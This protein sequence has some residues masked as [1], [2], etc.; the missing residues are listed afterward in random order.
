VKT[1]Q[2]RRGGT[3]ASVMRNSPVHIGSELKALRERSGFTQSNIAKYLKVDQSLISKFE[4][5]ERTLSADMLEKLA[6]LF[7]VDLTA[8]DGKIGRAHV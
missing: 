5:G 4:T 3:E 1:T 8:F 2:L 6:V 7:G